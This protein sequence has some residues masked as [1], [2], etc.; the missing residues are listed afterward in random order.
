[1]KVVGSSGV[2]SKLIFG[3]ESEPGVGISPLGQHVETF[4]IRNQ[5]ERFFS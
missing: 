4:V 1:M 5:K 2:I 3:A